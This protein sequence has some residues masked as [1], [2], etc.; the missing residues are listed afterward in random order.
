M[1][2]CQ[3]HAIL[4]SSKLLEDGSGQSSLEYHND[5][6]AWNMEQCKSWVRVVTT[7]IVLLTGSLLTLP[8]PVPPAIPNVIGFVIA[9]LINDAI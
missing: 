6:S 2:M 3:V 4:F 9:C 1:I 8:A 7:G 5:G